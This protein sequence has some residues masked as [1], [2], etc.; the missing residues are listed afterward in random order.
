MVRFPLGEEPWSPNQL[1]ICE[2]TTVLADPLSEEV[3]GTGL[4]SRVEDCE[5]D[6]GKRRL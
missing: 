1:N 6:G 5:K 3:H 2:D 4:S